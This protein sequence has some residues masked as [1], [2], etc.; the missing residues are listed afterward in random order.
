MSSHQ[1]KLVAAVAV[2]RMHSQFVGRQGENKPAAT[3]VDRW[4]AQHLGEEC[5]C[6]RRVRGEDDRV[7]AGDHAAI[8]ALGR[9]DHAG[10]LRPEPPM[11]STRG[12]AS[13]AVQLNGSDEDGLAVQAA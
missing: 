10:M 11:R 2:S 4:Q 8:L 13:P 9:H 1:V 12:I 6:L 3:R 5:P 7:Y